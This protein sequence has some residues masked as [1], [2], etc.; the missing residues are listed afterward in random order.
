MVSVLAV[1]IFEFL[2]G[3]ALFSLAFFLWEKRDNP[4]AVPL[5]VMTG[6]IATWAVAEG[7]QPLVASDTLTRGFS[8]VTHPLAALAALAWFYVAVEYTDTKRLQGRRL[9][10][11]LAGLWLV[12][13]MLVVTNPR[14]HLFVTPD[15]GV[16]QAGYFV[17]DFGVLYAYHLAYALGLLFVG[18]GLFADAFRTSHGVFRKQ[19]GSI[20][21]GIS[22]TTAFVCFE[23]LAGDVVPSLSFHLV[24]TAV[25]CPVL[26]W[27]TIQAEFLTRV[28]VS[29][30]RLLET[31]VEHTDDSVI[32]VDDD[33]HVIDINPAGMALVS[34]DS[35][36][37]MAVTEIFDAGSALGDR[38]AA[39]RPGE[40][41][42]PRD[43]GDRQYELTVSP[44]R[45][46]S[47]TVVTETADSGETSPRHKADSAGGH[48]TVIRDVTERVR[49]EAALADQKAELQ[50]QKATLER[51]NERLDKF[52]SMLS[53]DLRNPL[54]I[55]ETYLDFAAES[56]D[57]D[58]FE[59][60]VEAH[61][62]MEAMIE[63][64]LTL[65]RS[66]ATITDTEPVALESAARTAW[67]TAETPGAT[68]ELTADT[69]LDADPDTL[70]HVLENLFRNATDHNDG[71]VTVTVG[72]IGSDGFFVEDDGTGI[73]PEERDDVFDHGYTT[74]AEGTGFGLSIV[75]EFVQ[76]HGW[77]IDVT[78][79]ETGGARFEIRTPTTP[80]AVDR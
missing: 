37:G 5:I 34:V 42:V 53:H 22:V 23:L 51:Q 50:S 47:S 58:D 54:G 72:T 39:G 79:G 10:G 28:P 8:H 77:E 6:A 69:T 14:H 35:P 75:A 65:A 59:A 41:T 57:A 66:A 15:S 78:A 32:A 45:S 70:R 55:A 63:D 2:T 12:D 44:I 27:A 30:E 52:T 18:I 24:G 46:G 16:A 26:F 20:L 71:L 19:T 17:T 48:V 74:D 4:A 68:L 21:A 80:A 11:V 3:V 31:M 13:I 76:A 49:Q 56:G 38:L 40:V 64:L 61:D 9:F 73:P 1:S 36:I 43:E 62:R 67:N 7:V 29:R 60:V 25:L 33:A